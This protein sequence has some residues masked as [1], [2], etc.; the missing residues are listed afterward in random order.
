MIK[1]LEHFFILEEAGRCG[2]VQD[3]EEKDLGEYQCVH[4]SDCKE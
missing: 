3:E 1:G 4:I 2:T